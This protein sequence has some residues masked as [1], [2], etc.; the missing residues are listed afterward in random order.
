MCYSLNEDDHEAHVYLPASSQKLLDMG[1][2]Y[3]YQLQ[4]ALDESIE[5]AIKS[6]LL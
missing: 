2:S 4:E 3:K 5:F 1:F 6:G